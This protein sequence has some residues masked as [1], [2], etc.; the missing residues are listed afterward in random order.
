MTTAPA[1]DRQKAGLTPNPAGLREF[2]LN[3]SQDLHAHR[4]FTFKI[5]PC[6]SKQNPC[7][8][9]A[10]EPKAARFP[11]SCGRGVRKARETHAGSNIQGQKRKGIVNSV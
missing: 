10:D 2:Q 9:T 11:L 5:F 7:F 3:G 4:S 6:I 1:A 8:H